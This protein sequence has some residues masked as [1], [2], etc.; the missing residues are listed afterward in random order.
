MRSI[1]IVIAVVVFYTMMLVAARN[2]QTGGGRDVVVPDSMLVSPVADSA[3][4]T[5]HLPFA[6]PDSSWDTLK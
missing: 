5:E 2:G 6:L 4:P 1:T 3:A